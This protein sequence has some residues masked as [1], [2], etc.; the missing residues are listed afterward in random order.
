MSGCRIIGPYYPIGLIDWECAT[1]EVCAV[2]RD[3]SRYGAD[4]LRRE[5]FRCPVGEP[6]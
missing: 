4:N 5:D 1:H 2:L 3:P 6:E